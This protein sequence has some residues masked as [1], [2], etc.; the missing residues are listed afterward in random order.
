MNDYAIGFVIGFFSATAMASLAIYY[1]M[2]S[3]NAIIDAI[4]KEKLSIKE[5][6]QQALS[7]V[8]VLHE[9]MTIVRELKDE[10]SSMRESFDR[11]SNEKSE[12]LAKIA[13]LSTENEK[14]VEHYEQR[15][16]D[17]ASVQASMKESFTTL[18]EDALLKNSTMVASAFKQSMEHFFKAGESD[19]KL[20]NETLVNIMTP[21]KESLDIVDK[22]VQELEASRQGAYASL[23]EQIEA[24]MKSQST[25]QVE[26]NNLSRALNAPSI[27]GRWGEMQLRRVV[28]LS[29]LSSHCDFVLQKSVDDGDT[30]LRPDMIVTLPHNKKIVVDAKAPLEIF[31]DAYDQNKDDQRG[32]ELALSMK[33]HLLALKK[34]SYHSIV[35]QSPE[36]VVM[37]LPGEAF[38]HW[39]LLADPSLLDYAAQNEV[40]IATP[41]TLIALLKAIA[42]GFRQESIAN[43]I[44]EVRK[45]SQQLID[46]IG[47]VAM[48]F[49]KLGRSLKQATESYNQTLSS[50]DSRV[51]VT[52]RK[53]SEIKSITRGEETHEVSGL[54]EL[55]TVPREAILKNALSEA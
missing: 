4:E 1:F 3:K 43:N 16:N 26:T 13:R 22:K 42:F 7:E 8:A 49:E 48:H 54:Q 27:R 39:A 37:F 35:G 19:R 55:E 12:L 18:S 17:M 14:I 50:L 28:E 33:R 36:F 51:L 21:L 52:A 2:R 5:S 9:R 30:S 47:K 10:L 40:I 6:L 20:A 46:R 32:A 31:V 45:L 25:L 23:K 11:L 53:L 38:L 15:V 29:G 44:E 41:I 24:L 34:K